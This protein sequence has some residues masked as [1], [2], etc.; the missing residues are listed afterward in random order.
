MQT[1]PA[2]TI[3]SPEPF[4]AHA[5]AVPGGPWAPWVPWA[6]WAPWVPWVPWAP[7]VPGWRASA[8]TWSWSRF[9]FLFSFFSCFLTPPLALAVGAPALAAPPALAI[10]TTSSATTAAAIATRGTRRTSSRPISKST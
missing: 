3:V 8:S 10:W 7:W 9:S 5:G 2:G 4:P 1:V 6:P